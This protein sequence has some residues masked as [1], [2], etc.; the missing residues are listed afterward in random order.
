M[1]DLG[2][3]SWHLSIEDPVRANSQERWFDVN[4]PTPRRVAKW[5]ARRFLTKTLEPR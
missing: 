5:T 4:N 3:L 2:T 1:A